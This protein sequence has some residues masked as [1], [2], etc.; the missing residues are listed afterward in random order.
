MKR[1]KLFLIVDLIIYIN[2]LIFLGS[3][4]FALSEQKS[5][6]ALFFVLTVLNV[7]FMILTIKLRYRY[8]KIIENRIVVDIKAEDKMTGVAKETFN[9]SKQLF[10]E[11]RI[12]AEIEDKMPNARVIRNA[13]IPK[14]DGNDTEIDLIAVSELGI[15]I[16]ESKNI[17]G[18][19]FGNWQD[20]Q[21]TLEHPGGKTYKIP[22]PIKQNTMHYYHLKNILGLKSEIFRS[23]VVFGDLCIIDSFKGV[24]YH[25]HVTQVSY[26][27]YS[28]NRLGKKFNTKLEQY[29]IENIY[30]N[31]LKVVVK[32]DEREQKHI[33]RIRELS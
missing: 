19:L 23:I 9:R 4:L 8:N 10:L 2:A 1:E 5:M 18:K 15:F 27:I 31:L 22:N 13:Y 11:S 32:S 12:E 29:Q 25:A 6:A 16:I 28:M 30:E 33:D 24:P 7:V 21:M 17:S 3:G 14:S 26:L 20:D